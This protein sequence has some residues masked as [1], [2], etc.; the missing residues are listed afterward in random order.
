MADITTKSKWAFWTLIATVLLFSTVPS[1]V[2][3][4]KAREY[5]RFFT[6]WTPGTLKQGHVRRM[7]P[8]R[9]LGRDGM[10]LRFVEFRVHA[11]KAKKVFLAS[12][13]NRWKEDSLP[14][15]PRGDGKWEVAVP[16]P[17]GTYYYA[18]QVDG[19]WTPDPE[20]A[21]KARHADH[22]VSVRKVH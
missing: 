5:W 19:V 1:M 20:S 12:N 13:F 4:D 22:D 10:D 6:G 3:I 9:D 21:E 2:F 15:H 11:P 7:P 14:L 17:P 16:L 18:F 8:Q